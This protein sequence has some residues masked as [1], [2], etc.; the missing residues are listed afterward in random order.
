MK[1]VL[2]SEIFPPKPV[3]DSRDIIL[4]TEQGDEHAGKL[5]LCTDV[6]LGEKKDVYEFVDVESVNG[7][8]EP[9]Q[10]YVKHADL[11]AHKKVSFIIGLPHKNDQ[12]DETFWSHIGD[13]AKGIAATKRF[14]KEGALELGVQLHF[15]DRSGSFYERWRDH[16]VIFR[17]ERCGSPPPYLTV[18]AQGGAISEACRRHISASSFLRGFFETDEQRIHDSLTKAGLS[19]F[20]VADWYKSYFNVYVPCQNERLVPKPYGNL[21]EARQ[22]LISEL[23]KFLQ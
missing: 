9:K 23:E 18:S 21:T 7:E 19:S 8:S 2:Q 20:S 3:L 17:Y 15:Y 11:A 22:E 13:M 6:G 12:Y 14:L 4:V 16:D 10:F 5:L 1:T